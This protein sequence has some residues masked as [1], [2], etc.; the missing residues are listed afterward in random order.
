M[1]ESICFVFGVVTYNHDHSSSHSH[2]VLV[3]VAH[4]VAH[5][6]AS[7]N[8][9]SV[10]ALS[11]HPAAYLHLLKRMEN[12][13]PQSHQASVLDCWSDPYGVHHAAALAASAPAPHSPPLQIFNAD[14]NGTGDGLEQLRR[15]LVCNDNARCTCVF[16]D[17]LTPIV[18]QFGVSQTSGFLHSLRKDPGTS[19]VVVRVHTDLH[20]QHE[21]DALIYN[22]NC[23]VG[24]EPPPKLSSEGP[25]HGRAVVRC[26]KRVGCVR[27]EI[28]DYAVDAQGIARFFGPVA[29][30]SIPTPERKGT[31]SKKETEDAAAGPA[32]LL[33]QALAG[34]MRLHLT[35]DEEKARR[36]VQLPYEHR[37][38][39]SRYGTGD[40]R[41]YLPEAAGG[42]RAAGGQLGH[43]LYVRDSDSEEPD[44]DEDPD[45]DLDI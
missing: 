13:Q 14:E 42:R 39:G 11:S 19:C 43:I 22:A 32:E 8:H 41:D 28:Q 1:N 29:M 23:V 33:P 10:V 34:G 30:P 6:R 25:C 3:S 45:D 31:F 15:H 21:V 38:E 4:S 18:D 35:E 36:E 27:A 20:K 26:R 5:E 37:G 7:G 40:Y 12:T 44:S 16:V 2:Q 17:S 24:L 9:V